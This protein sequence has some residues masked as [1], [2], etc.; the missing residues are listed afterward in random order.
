MKDETTLLSPLPHQASPPEGEARLVVLTGVSAGR[1]FD[2]EGDLTIGRSPEA[3]VRI[4]ETSVSREHARI[5]RDDGG[6]YVLTDLRSR[7]G[8]T[9]NDDLVDRCV[10]SYGDRVRIGAETVLLFTHHHP[11]EEQLRRKQRMEAIGELSSGIAHD[12][13]N[14]LGAVLASVEYLRHLP[15]ERS[16]GDPDVR[17]CVEDVLA[18]VVRGSELTER[19]LG[20]ARRGRSVDDTVDV[21]SLC[22]EVLQLARRT[23]PRKI[24]VRGE[25]GRDLLVI[26]NRSQL[27]HALLNLCINA[28]D[29]MM[30]EGGDLTLVAR[31]SNDGG[32]VVIVVSDTGI[33]MDAR[34]TERAFEPFF[35]TKGGDAGSGLGLASV[36]ATVKSLGGR[37]DLAST[38]GA[39]TSFT[40]TLPSRTHSAP[41]TPWVAHTVRKG[42]ADTGPDGA[43]GKGLVLLVDDDAVLRRSLARVL[44]QA[45]HDLVLAAEGEEAVRL[46]RSAERKPDVVL[47]DLDMPRL[48]G[49]EAFAQLKEIDPAVRVVFL[50]GLTSDEQQSR[51][52][53]QGAAECLQKP[54]DALT[55]VR[56]IARAL[57]D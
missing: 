9:V 28:R 49:E 37:I 12:F 46:F 43:P 34:T 57:R 21:S 54:C 13:N 1:S 16:V 51:L 42:L 14:L 55:L 5:T 53:A 24:R 4:D 6:R 30:P 8:T 11:L 35:T 18:A 52:L 36:Q 39:G 45:G 32:Q 23:F 26:G 22:A 15:P 38:R 41:R 20:A 44:G 17:E 48:G 25:L 29:A 3:D 27:Y 47:L 7:N 40:I 50:S 10:L 33:G 56:T 2:V 31:A 19:L